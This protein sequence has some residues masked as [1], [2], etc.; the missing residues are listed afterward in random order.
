MEIGPP[1]S[2]GPQHAETVGFEPTVPR[3]GHSTLAGWRLANQARLSYAPRVHPTRQTQHPPVGGDTRGTL[4]TIIPPSA[5]LSTQGT[6]STWCSTRSVSA[7]TAFEA[8]PLPL[9][10]AD[11]E[12]ERG[13]KRELVLA[14]SSK[15]IA[16][17]LCPPERQEPP[18]QN[19][20]T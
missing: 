15:A 10:V 19:K 17:E 7:S 5:R 12:R 8:G 18:P 13:Y 4:D 16:T 20:W 2:R 6:L 11:A 3:K 14:V 1:I 9:E